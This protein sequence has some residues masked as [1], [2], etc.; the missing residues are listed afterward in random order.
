MLKYT[1]S[2]VNKE[3][4]CLCACQTHFLLLSKWHAEYNYQNALSMVLTKGDI[5]IVKGM[6]LWDT[7]KSWFK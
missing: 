6:G 4:N 5:D 1:Y 2:K 7:Y 3:L